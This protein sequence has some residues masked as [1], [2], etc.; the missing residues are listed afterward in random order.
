[1]ATRDYVIKFRRDVTVRSACEDVGCQAW[2]NGWETIVDERTSLGQAQADYIRR[3][4]GRDFVEHDFGE[5]IVK[6]RFARRQRCFAEHRTRPARFLAGGIP[7][8]DL[9]AWVGDF[10]QHVQSLEDQARKG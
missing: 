7:V 6:F 10:D 2:A 1:M 8:P 3:R 5:G 9:S 4:S